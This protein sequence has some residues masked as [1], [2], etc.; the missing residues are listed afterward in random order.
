LNKTLPIHSKLGIKS[1][2]TT[3]KTFSKFSFKRLLF[4]QV[5]NENFRQKNAC[6]AAKEVDRARFL[7]SHGTCLFSLIKDMYCFWQLHNYK[8]F[9][10]KKNVNKVLP[11]CTAAIEVARARFL[12]FPMGPDS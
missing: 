2:M 4:W 10:T 7:L 8:T 6:T 9:L 3:E 11:S 1:Q 12:A 5:H